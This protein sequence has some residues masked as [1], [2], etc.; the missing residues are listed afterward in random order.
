MTTQ[1]DYRITLA[2]NVLTILRWREEYHRKNGSIDMYIAYGSA[3]DMLWYAL[4]ED[5]AS[6]A[7][8]DYSGIMR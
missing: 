6:L 2:E 5:S 8:F 7:Q 1:E 4:Q 3:A